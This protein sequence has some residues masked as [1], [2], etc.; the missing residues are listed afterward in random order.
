MTASG[1]G[2]VCRE[3]PDT[4][5][6]FRLDLKGASKVGPSGRSALSQAAGDIARGTR[7]SIRAS[8]AGALDRV[9]LLL[10]RAELGVAQVGSFEVGS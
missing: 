7:S 1:K 6:R 3:T 9:C 5:G 10:Q 8:R 4:P 2:S